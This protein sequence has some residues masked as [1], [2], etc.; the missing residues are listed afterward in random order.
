MSLQEINGDLFRSEHLK[1]ECVMTHCISQDLYMNAGIAKEFKKL[2]GNVDFLKSQNKVVGEIA[3]LEFTD[4]LRI[5]YLVTK[6]RYYEKPTYSSLQESL[7]KLLEYYKVNNLSCPIIMPKIG[8]GLDRLDWIRVKD[9]I[10]SILVNN[11]INVYV[12]IL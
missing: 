3:I 7:S 4:I 11:G 6:K 10:I 2:Y 5:T 1:A 9:I 8:C 12:Y